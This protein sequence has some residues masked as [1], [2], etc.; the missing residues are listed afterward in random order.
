MKIEWSTK[1]LAAFREVSDYPEKMRVAAAQA[2]N[3]TAEQTRG[4][5]VDKLG[6]EIAFP[7]GYLD[8]SGGRLNVQGAASPESLQV[9]I[10]AR[11]RPT[12]LARFASSAVVGKSGVSV[13]VKPG[14]SVSMPRAFLIRLRSGNIGLAMRLRPGESMRR[15]RA[16]QQMRN[17]LWLLYGPSVSQGFAQHLDHGSLVAETEKRMDANF[18][19]FMRAQV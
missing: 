9:R 12:S 11:G 4:V 5:V 14:S 19:T 2:L 7:P 8:K 10:S 17:G 6:R 3:A 16:A 15:S 1:G 13:E 18:S